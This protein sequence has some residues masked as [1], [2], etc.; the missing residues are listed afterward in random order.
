MVLRLPLVLLWLVLAQVAVG[1]PWD[2][3]LRALLPVR[4]A[5]EEYREIQRLSE[6]IAGP[7][8]LVVGLGRSPTPIIR[9]RQLL[10]PG[11]AFNLPLTNF[12]HYP[13]GPHSQLPGLT[14]EEKHE[15]FRPLTVDEKKR[16]FEHFDRFFPSAGTIGTKEVVL[17]DFA[18]G[19]DSLFAA[20]AYLDLY[21]AER[22]RKHKVRLVAMSRGVNVM[23]VNQIAFATGTQVRVVETRP[24]KLERKMSAQ[25]YEWAAEYGP[26]DLKVPPAKPLEPRP[27]YDDL[28]REL[29]AHLRRD[30]SQPRFYDPNARARDR[31]AFG[32]FTRSK[33][34]Q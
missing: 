14:E 22:G 20:K 18:Q 8:V 17:L 32:W 25:G 21:L 15:L 30:P 26:F 2:R 29:L 23:Q 28:G 13:A 16:L 10:S 4:V 6:T 27:H 34:R 7:D 31:C 3:V 9:Y 19:G 24:G 11:S 33:P 12:R 5:D 1:G